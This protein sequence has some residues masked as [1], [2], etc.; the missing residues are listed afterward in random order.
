MKVYDKKTKPGH[1]VTGGPLNLEMSDK[2]IAAIQKHRQFEDSMAKMP[3]VVLN[4]VAP[5][6][7]PKGE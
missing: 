7:K 5:K 4:W 6:T 1:L 3:K 2:G